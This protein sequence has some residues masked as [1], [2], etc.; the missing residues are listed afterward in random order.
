MKDEFERGIS[1]ALSEYGIKVTEP[2]AIAFSG[3]ADSV[4]LLSAV[5][6]LGFNVVALH[7]NFHLR[8]AESDRDEVFCRTFCADRGIDLRV[9]EF[10]TADEQLPG[11]SLEM[12]CRRLRYD[13]FEEVKSAEGIRFLLTGH[14]KDDNHETLLLNMFRGT[15]LRGM[16]GIKSFGDR[17]CSPMLKFSRK[18]ILD[19]LAG[20]G[21]DYVTDSTNLESEY[22]RNRIR[23]K[24]LPLVRSEFPDGEKGI[25]TTISNLNDA[26]LFLNSVIEEKRKVYFRDNKVNLRKLRAEEPESATLLYYLLE[27]YG[28]NRS[29]T[30]SMIEAID[31]NGAEFLSDGWRGVVSDGCLE[32]CVSR[33]AEEQPLHYSIK[34]EV[35]PRKKLH[36]FEKGHKKLYLDADKTGDN[37]DLILRRWREGDRMSPFGMQGKTRLVS[38]IFSDARLSVLQ[39]EQVPVVEYKGQIVWLYGLKESNLYTIDRNTERVLIVTLIN[40]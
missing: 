10:R 22:R 26:Y 9:K 35:I 5:E 12:T 4:A 14:H 37:P 33:D 13:W 16:A 32:L 29:Q 18:D 2:V 24:I 3:G 25:A 39:K 38:D 11:E 15:G 17:R 20:N 31:N 6:S 21:T 28:Y 27:E 36:T 8:G 40:Q 30:D 34:T 23:N 19:Y 7:C 1:R